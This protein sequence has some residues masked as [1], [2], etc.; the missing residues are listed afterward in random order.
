MPTNHPVTG[1]VLLTVK[2]AADYR[3]SQGLPTTQ[4]S[5]NSDRSNGIGPKFLKIGRRVYYKQVTLDEY[6]QSKT[7]T[8][9]SSTSEL[10]NTKQFLIEDKSKDKLN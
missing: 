1:E 4:A 7:T 2:E 3:T 5:L 8:E 9:V 10:K 6:V